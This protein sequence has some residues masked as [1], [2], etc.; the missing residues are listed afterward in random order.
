MYALVQRVSVQTIVIARQL[1]I[2]IIVR[3]GKD[4]VILFMFLFQMIP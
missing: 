4:A 2:S 3:V 1:N